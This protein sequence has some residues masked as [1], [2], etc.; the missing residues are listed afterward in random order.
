MV[1][2]MEAIRCRG[3]TKRYG[4]RAVVDGLD[5]D[6]EAGQVFGAAVF[7]SSDVTV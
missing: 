5:L 7:A 1:V 4:G 6:V 2:V 3:L